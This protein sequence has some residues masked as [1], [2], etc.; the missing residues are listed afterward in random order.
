MTVLA[1]LHQFHCCQFASETLIVFPEGASPPLIARATG[2]C[3]PWPFSYFE[4]VFIL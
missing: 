1:P 3:N 4:V 2:L